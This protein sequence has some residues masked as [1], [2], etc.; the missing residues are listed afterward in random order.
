MGIYALCVASGGNTLCFS[1]MPLQ[2]RKR[3]SCATS[4]RPSALA[5][6]RADAVSLDVACFAV[7]A[8]ATA[9]PAPT[10]YVT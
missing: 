6:P 10:P 3:F 7:A 4:S 2:P 5:S 8:D 9:A 1:F